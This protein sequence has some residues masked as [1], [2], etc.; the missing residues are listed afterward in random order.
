MTKPA[1]SIGELSRLSGISAHTL[2]FYE[3]EGI[4]LPVER[5]GNGHRRYRQDDVLWLEFVMR[6][7]VTGMPL[8]QI[9]QYALLRAQGEKT[10]AARLAMLQS[11]QAHLL[12]KIH[13]LS[14]CS[15]VLDKKMRVYRKM[16]AG[17]RAAGRKVS[18]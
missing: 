4:L 14:L 10:L 17:P 12:A 15:E 16:M 9:R 8:A 3:A 1:I 13:E 7:K 2:R 18:K 6:L 5:A 11:H